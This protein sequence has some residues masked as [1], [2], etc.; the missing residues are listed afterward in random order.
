MGQNKKADFEYPF[1]HGDLLITLWMVYQ[2]TK[3][4]Q[5]Y[6]LPT[7]LLERKETTQG[8]HKQANCDYKK[9]LQSLMAVIGE[10]WGWINNIVVTPQY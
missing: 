8:F 10:N 2:Y 4:L 9:L 5:R 1:D 6:R 7:Q 3:S